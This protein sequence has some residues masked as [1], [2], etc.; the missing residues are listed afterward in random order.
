M[1]FIFLLNQETVLFQKCLGLEEL[2]EISC[3]TTLSFLRW[4][5]L[6][7]VAVTA[8]PE[9]GTV[10]TA[11]VSLGVLCSSRLGFSGAGCCLLDIHH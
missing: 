6:S 8:L 11:Q 10:A 3:V 4:K 2:V 5:G 1:Y 9:P 7:K